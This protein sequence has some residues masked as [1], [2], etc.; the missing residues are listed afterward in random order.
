MNVPDNEHSQSVQPPSESYS[1]ISLEKLGSLI[2]ARRA[3]MSLSQ[4]ELAARSGLH[5]SYISEIERGQRNFT[6][7]VLAQIAET[8][9][10]S[11]SQLIQQAG[12]EPAVEEYN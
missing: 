4:E 6:I 5:R 7:K 1:G 10:L 11:M 9:N 2:A 8:L 12:D 3:S